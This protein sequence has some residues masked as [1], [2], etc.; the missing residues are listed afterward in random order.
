MILPSSICM[1]L[2]VLICKIFIMGS[3]P[4]AKGLLLLLTGLKILNTFSELWLSRFPVGS[5][6]ISKV[7]PFINALAMATR[8]FSPPENSR[9]PL[10]GQV[11]NIEHP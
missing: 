9:C 8:C 6:P 1:I 4:T 10:F 2:S 3:P 5:S 11:I 7:G